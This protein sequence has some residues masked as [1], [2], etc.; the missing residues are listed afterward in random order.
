METMFNKQNFCHVASNN[1]N[2]QKAGLFVYKTTDDLATVAAS[3]YF[4]EKIIDINLHDLIIHEWHDPTDRT[5]VQ[6]NILCVVE[7]TLENVGTIVIKSKWEGDIEQAIENIQQQINNL[8]QTFLKLDGTNIMTGPLKMRS[9]VSFKCAIAPSWDGVG[10]YKLNDNDSLTLM[11]S[12]ESTDGLCPATNNTYNIGKASY[13][14]KNAYVGK[15]F[16]AVLNNGYDIAVPVTNS[17]DTLALKSQVDD[18]ANS[19][20]QLYTTGVWYAKMYAASTVPTGAEYDGT[21][22]ADFSQV[23]TDN[24]PIIVIYEGQSGAWV[25]IDRITPPATYNGYITVTSKIWDIVEQTDQ[26]GG[27]VLWSY[28]QKTFTPYPRIVSVAGFAKTDLD[29]LTDKGQNITNWS[30]NVTNCITEIPQDIKLELNAGTLTLKAGSKVYVPNGAGVFDTITTIT[31][32][33]LTATDNATYLVFLGTDQNLHYFTGCGSGT[34]TPTSGYV[35]YYNTSDNKIYRIENGV[36]SGSM[37]FPI[38]E[39]TISGGAISSIDQVFNGF[40][41][42]GEIIFILP[43]ISGLV[44]NGLNADGSYKN[45]KYTQPDVFVTD[46]T[47]NQPRVI[48]FQLDINGNYVDFYKMNQQNV[49]TGLAKDRPTTV[50]NNNRHEWYSIDENQ[51]YTTSG[52]TTANWQKDYPFFM[53]IRETTAGAITYFYKKS[54]FCALDK[55]DTEY[56]THQAM[57]SSRYTNLTLGA[58]N[59]TYT[60]PADGFVVF[61]KGATASGQR[62]GLLGPT[63][64]SVI[65]S[66]AASQSLEVYI[67]VSKGDVVTIR[68]TA[69]GTTNTFRFVYGNGAV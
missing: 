62:I 15:V 55:N 9:S 42:I 10:F 38:A 2:E 18:A 27:Q 19:G 50:D 11:A 16:T 49:F 12:M 47:A 17:A 54:E 28:N 23:D 57:P 35:G 68:Y 5:K 53:G 67:P 45:I 26:Q 31:D 40:G 60:T 43:G 36:N 32:K 30:S 8:D 1:R 51:W 33:T 20:S 14:W 21:N 24:N 61:G 64:G 46:A 3:G 13:K 22:Y 69:A 41:Y 7:R 66:S 52:S 4:N 48:G 25:E 6:R 56:I 39:I 59:T 34:S 44:P 58:D 29:N 37:S 63:V 65:Y